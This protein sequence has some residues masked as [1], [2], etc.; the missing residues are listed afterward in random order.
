M[1][2]TTP[3]LLPASLAALL[4]LSAAALAA[5][6]A[7]AVEGPDCPAAGPAPEALC[8]CLVQQRWREVGSPPDPVL[9]AVECAA[10]TYD[11][12]VAVLAVGGYE[13]HGISYHLAFRRAGLWAPIATL[14]EKAISGTGGHYSEFEVAT[15]RAIE[16]GAARLLWVE[17]RSSDGYWHFDGS[18]GSTD[19]VRVTLCRLPGPGDEP[20]GCPLQAPILIDREWT[21][22]DGAAEGPDAAPEGGGTEL[23]P[24]GGAEDDPEEDGY[25]EETVRLEIRISADGATAEVVL[26]EGDLKDRAVRKK[27]GSHSLR[28]E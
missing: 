10:E 18:Q 20:A 3:R 21:D 22:P 27:L 19:I 5:E 2:T 26:L 13:L 24:D 11:T 16:R 4:W 8:P 23:A 15:V 12:G 14:G 28:V 9:T 17:T 6:T 25:Y 1:K 7:M